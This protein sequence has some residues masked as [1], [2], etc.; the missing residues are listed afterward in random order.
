[1]P[2]GWFAISVKIF[3]AFSS[4]SVWTFDG[5]VRMTAPAPRFCT[6]ALTRKRAR[7]G[8]ANEKSHSRFSS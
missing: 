5:I 4:S 6:N 1:M 8:I 2:R 7:P 3:G